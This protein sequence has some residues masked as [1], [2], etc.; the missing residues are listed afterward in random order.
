MKTITNSIF[1]KPFT[2]DF[3]VF[4]R[5]ATGIIILIHFLSF[6]K[7]FDLLYTNN[8]I[9]PL[10]LHTIYGTYNVLTV[11]SILAFFNNFLD[12]HQSILLF[13]FSYIFLCLMIISGF[14]SRLSAIILIILQISFIKSGSLFFYGADFFTSMSLFYIVIFPSS[15]YFSIQKKLF[16]LFSESKQSLTLCKRL[17]QIHLCLAYFFSGLDKIL[18]FNWWNGESVWK[19]VHLP[20]LYSYIEIG[21]HIQN[22]LF[23]IILGWG[24]IIIELFYPIFININKTRKIWLMLT[25]SM[26]LGIILSF[27]LFFFSSIMIVWN[28]TSYYFNYYH[29]NK[30]ISTHSHPSASGIY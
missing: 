24:V 30:T 6:W 25:I 5:I 7:D 20:N 13:K 17:I 3:I 10:E 12:N 18:G 15:S 14:F 1:S 8:S 16:P 29:E 2:P 26:H 23:Y 11:E 21:N 22:P 19:A 9:I 28:L 27:N 4:F